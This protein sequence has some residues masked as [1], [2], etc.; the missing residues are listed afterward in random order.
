MV[1]LSLERTSCGSFKVLTKDVEV[2][3]PNMHWNSWTSFVF[4]LIMTGLNILTIVVF[5]LGTKAVLKQKGCYLNHLLKHLLGL[6][7]LEILFIVGLQIAYEYILLAD[8]IKHNAVNFFP[9]DNQFVDLRNIAFGF[10]NQMRLKAVIVGCLIR[11][12]LLLLVSKVSSRWTILLVNNVFKSNIKYV[13]FILILPLTYT[14]I[15]Q[16][17]Q[18]RYNLD[19]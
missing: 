6:E 15:G 2:F 10:K 19:Y 11:K 9:T 1:N 12:L 14:E 4:T 8:F 3:L 5:I 17:L 18:G 16:I 7:N 13:M